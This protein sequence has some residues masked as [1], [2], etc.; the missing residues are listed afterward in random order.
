M[1]EKTVNHYADFVMPEIRHIITYIKSD[2]HWA[3]LNAIINNDKIYHPDLLKLFDA[4]EEEISPILKDLARAGVVFR[5]SKAQF[6]FCK[7]LHFYEAS[8]LGKKLIE[9]LYDAYLPK[10]ME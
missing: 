7:K 8:N 10:D 3:V 9:A 6:I 1:D 5:Y 2:K 4:T